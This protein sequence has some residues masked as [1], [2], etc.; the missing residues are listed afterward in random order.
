[1]ISSNELEQHVLAG[2]IRYPEIFHDIEY[3]IDEKDFYNQDSIVHQTIFKIVKQ[4]SNAREP[5]DPVIIA[6]RINSIGISFEDNINVSDY[7]Q[8]LSMRRVAQGQVISSCKE[9]KKL[10]VKREICNSAKDVISSMKRINSEASYSEIVSEA[11]SVFNKTIN[12]F[13]CGQDAPVNI[14][15]NMEA[16]IEE[17]GNNPVTDFGLKG[18]HEK[19]HDLYGSLLRPGNI[20]VITARSGVG[21]TQFCMDFCTKVSAANDVPVLHFDNGEMSLE[22][23]TMRQ[24]AAL[25]GVPLHL[26]ETGKWRTAGK[27]VCNKIRS[28]F[29]KVKNLKF[30]YQNVGGLSVKEMISLVKRFYYGKIGRGNPLILSFDYIKTSYSENSSNMKEWEQIGKMVN[31]FKQCIQR[32]ILV[33]G[34]PVIPMITSV[35]T[36][37]MGIS[38]NRNSDTVVEDESVVSLSDRITQFCS[39]MFFLRPKTTD[40]VESDMGFGSHKLINLKSRHLGDDVFGA[41]EPVKMPDGRLKKNYIN[42]NFDN[43]GIS[44]VGDLRDLVNHL[45]ASGEPALDGNDELPDLFS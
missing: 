26:C 43:F 16:M 13:D 14:Y 20:T 15:E 22:E 6:E 24:C 12:V 19:L 38:Q 44:E 33:D 28:V 45:E 34:K 9:L 10:T 4:L 23:L 21:K 40:E 37:R 25:S 7:V 41:L 35:Q 18:P 30:Y 3:F 29:P 42:L 2:L 27:D 17:L 11:D 36:N 31:D 39:H 1:M 5:I 8:A 32:D